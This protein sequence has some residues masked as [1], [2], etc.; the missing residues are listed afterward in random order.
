MQAAQ[1]H[2]QGV[3]PLGKHNQMDVIGPQAVS[4]DGDLGVGEIVAQKPQIR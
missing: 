2:G 3:L 4:P 1:Q